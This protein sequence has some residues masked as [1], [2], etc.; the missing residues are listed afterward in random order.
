M[1]QGNISTV[2][3]CDTQSVTG[4]LI[5][6][7]RENVWLSVFCYSESTF[8]ANTDPHSTVSWVDKPARLIIRLLFGFAS[9]YYI[10][11]PYYIWQ[12]QPIY[13][14]WPTFNRVLRER[15]SQSQICFLGKEKRP[16]WLGRLLRNPCC[17]CCWL[18]WSWSWS[19]PRPR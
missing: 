11:L 16:G 15:N 4:W 8:L 17:C 6:F 10:I 3:D 19:R 5:K 14:Y 9:D 18:S 1:S 13:K 2:T 7:H 12:T